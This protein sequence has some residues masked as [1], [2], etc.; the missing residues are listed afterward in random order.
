MVAHVPEHVAGYTGSDVTRRVADPAAE[1]VWTLPQL[2]DLLDEWIVGCFT[3]RDWSK[4]AP[5]LRY[6]EEYMSATE[7]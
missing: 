4:C 2:Q 5:D 6:Y 3:D 7:K 1:A